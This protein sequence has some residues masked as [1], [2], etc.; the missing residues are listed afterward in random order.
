MADNKSVKAANSPSQSKTINIQVA[1]YVA[2]GVSWK[3]ICSELNISKGLFYKIKNSDLFQLE[4][5]KQ[6]ASMPDVG[7]LLKHRLNKVAGQGL[8]VLEKLM[9]L[10]VK[11]DFQLLKLQG[12]HAQEILS[13]AGFGSTANLNVDNRTATANILSPE[14]Q[15]LLRIEAENL[16]GKS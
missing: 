1:M 14:E 12:H 6:L 13:K 4:L 15:E 16:R 11:D 3:E 9:E 8:D 2:A 7:T 10:D 5:N